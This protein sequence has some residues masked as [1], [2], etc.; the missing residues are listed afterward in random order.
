M[1]V[2]KNILNVEH[3]YIIQPYIKWGPKKSNTKP[4]LQLEEAEALVRSIPTWKIVESVKVPLESLDK[5]T[6]FGSGK[7]NELA[8]TIKALSNV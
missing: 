3:V 8:D 5:K 7:L 4:E 6:L 1:H 2:S